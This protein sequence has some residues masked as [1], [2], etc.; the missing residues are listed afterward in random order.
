MCLLVALTCEW[1]SM[2]PYFQKGLTQII[3]CKQLLFICFLNL[4]PITDETFT[5]PTD[6]VDINGSSNS[7]GA[8]ITAKLNVRDCICS[9]MILAMLLGT[10]MRR[11]YVILVL[12]S[13]IVLCCRLNCACVTGQQ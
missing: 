3:L 10:D 5:P 7:L 6:N 8:E 13:I 12:G 2:Q 1:C 9:G 11:E 4:S